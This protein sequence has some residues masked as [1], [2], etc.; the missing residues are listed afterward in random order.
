MRPGVA[1]LDFQL[2]EYKAPRRPKIQNVLLLETAL[3]HLQVGTKHR[4]RQCRPIWRRGASRGTAAAAGKNQRGQVSMFTASREFTFS[5][6][7]QR[8]WALPPSATIRSIS[9]VSS[10]DFLWLVSDYS[11]ERDLYFCDT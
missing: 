4:R 1:D 9:T 2:D 7:D 6:V 8:A 5:G 3:Q 10:L 11:S